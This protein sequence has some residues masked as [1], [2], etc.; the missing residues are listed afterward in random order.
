MLEDIKQIEILR[1]ARGA[2]WGANAFNG[3]IDIITK[4]PEE[5]EGLLA[6]SRVDHYGDTCH[7]ARRAG[8]TDRWGWRVSSSYNDVIS[9]SEA[10]DRDFVTVEAPFVTYE[11]RDSRRNVVDLPARNPRSH[12]LRR[13]DPPLLTRWLSGRNRA[14]FAIDLRLCIALH[15]M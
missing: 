14:G 11:S 4:E 15:S 12:L 5:C 9:S 3:A 13:A 6:S 1:G 7:Q 2:A 10:L 8:G